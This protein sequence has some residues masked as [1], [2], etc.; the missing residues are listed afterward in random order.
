MQI[1]GSITVLKNANLKNTN[2]RGAYLYS[3]NLQGA[4]LDGVNLQETKLSDV[5]YDNQTIWPKD[6]DYQNCGAYYIGPKANLQGADLEYANLERANLEG[7]NLKDA[8]L[9]DSDLEGANLRWANLK[10]ACLKHANLQGT[11]L[12]DV[13]LCSANLE[14][15][16]YDDKTIWPHGFDPVEAGAIFKKEGEAMNNRPVER[17]IERFRDILQKNHHLQYQEDKDFYHL[18][19][20]WPQEDGSAP[21]HWGFSAEEQH[22]LYYMTRKNTPA[23]RSEYRGFWG[24]FC[25]PK[26]LGRKFSSFL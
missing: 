1:L 16:L 6:F 15:A 13:D 10:E 19:W 25:P 24:S 20:W 9:E 21:E 17:L 26:Q 14:Y 7:A 23:E 3:T 4:D 11:N 12:K 8:N 5:L 2:L 18:P 22:L